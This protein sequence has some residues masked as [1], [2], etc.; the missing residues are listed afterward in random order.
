MN[1]LPAGKSIYF[2]S[3]HHF[4]IPDRDRSLERELR[5]VRWLDHI[6]PD[7]YELYIMG[8]LFDFWFEYRQVV[9]RGY[10]LLFGALANMV[11]N[12]IPV[13]YFR[14]N[15][16]MWAFDYFEQEL[17]FCMHHEPIVKSLGNKQF[18]LAHGDGLGPGDH[19]Y[20]FLKSVFASRVNQWLFRQIHPDLSFRIALFWSRRSRYANTARE[21]REDA[22]GCFNEADWLTSRRLPRFAAQMVQQDPSLDYLVF[23]HWHLPVELTFGK[24]KYFNIGDWISWFSYLRFDGATLEH[25]AFE[26]P[27]VIFNGLK[28]N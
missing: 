13:H 10:A 7:A 3:D 17:G 5:F 8:D 2:T 11:K 23:G 21:G 18:Y 22:E 12:G 25:H 16:D 24:A 4:G 20:K 15:H 28:N 14:G 1:N 19:G 6:A 26:T 9:P 27:A